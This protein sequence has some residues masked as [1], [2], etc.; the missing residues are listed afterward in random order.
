MHRTLS[1]DYAVILTGEVVLKLDGGRE[2]TVKAGDMIVQR[3]VNHEWHN[4]TDEWT[5][6]LVVMVAAE[7]VKLGDG[8]VLEET[9]F[10]K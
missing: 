10:K 1:V 7:A 6:I 3:G 9:V 2:K 8:T 5:R 4:R